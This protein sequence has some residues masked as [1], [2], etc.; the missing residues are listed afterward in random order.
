MGIRFRKYVGPR[1]PYTK[2]AP[3]VTAVKLTERNVAE[4][5]A[6]INKNNG[7]AIDES[8]TFYDDRLKDGVYT[9]VKVALVQKNTDA[10]GKVKKGVRK[11]FGGDLIVRT[12]VELPTGKTGY[13][14]SRIRDAGIDGYSL[15]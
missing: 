13:E 5:V 10:K 12:E 14:F 9:A 7:T 1:A 11:A 2:E 8:R 3:V 15:T 4:V 6:Y